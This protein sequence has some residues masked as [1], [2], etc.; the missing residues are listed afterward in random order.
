[1]IVRLTL[2]AAVMFAVVTPAFA[3][4]YVASLQVPAT[5]TKLIS[6]ERMWSCNGVVCV[7]G[8]DASS[9]AKHICSR[10]V[11]EVGPLSGFT[12]QGKVFA[13]DELAECNASA[14]R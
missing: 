4:N 11:K 8:G 13:A 14:T 2:I 1:M 9:A 5:A 10:L 6:S 3:A 7:A 12:A